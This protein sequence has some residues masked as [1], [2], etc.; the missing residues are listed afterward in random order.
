M[1]TYASGTKVPVEK[2]L[3]NIRRVLERFGAK[4]T[5]FYETPLL[6]GIGFAVK[7]RQFR[8]PFP[9]PNRRDF[10]STPAYNQALREQWAAIEL[11]LKSVLTAV[12]CGFFTVNQVFMSFAI[13]PNG[14]TVDEWLEEQLQISD[15]EMPPLLPWA[16]KKPKAIALPAPAT[17]SE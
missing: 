11:Y 4:E 16:E 9:L 15:R 14:Q 12:E 10:Y 5:I 6:I 3:V 17:R 13:L 1:A 7:G 8:L 2:R